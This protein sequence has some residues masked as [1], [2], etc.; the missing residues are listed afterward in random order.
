ML[1]RHKKIRSWSAYKKPWE[2]L[3]ATYPGPL[4]NQIS[5]QAITVV[6]SLAYSHCIQS[7][8]FTTKDGSRL[9]TAVRVTD[10]HKVKG[11]WRIVQEHVSSFRADGR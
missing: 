8:Y 2:G 1:S 11:K 5:E 3:F 9:D 4:K 6:G 10:V 7:G